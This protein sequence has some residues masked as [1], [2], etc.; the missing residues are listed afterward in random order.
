MD[1]VVRGVSLSLSVFVYVC[2]CVCVCVYVYVCCSGVR[3]AW[4]SKGYI[5]PMISLTTG[6]VCVQFI[7]L[8]VSLVHLVSAVPS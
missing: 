2:V 4:E 6:V 5:H 8:I 7:G 1:C 3:L